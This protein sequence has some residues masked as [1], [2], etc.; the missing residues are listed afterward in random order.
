MKEILVKGAEPISGFFEPGGSKNAALPII[1]AAVAMRGVSVISR[2]PDILDVRVAIEII[3]RFGAYAEMQNGVLK[4]DATDLHYEKIPRE[5]TCKIRASSYLIGACLA[6]F[7]RFHLDDFGGCNFCNRPIDMHLQAAAVLGAEITDNFIYAEKLT[8]RI[9]AFEKPSVGATINALIMASCAKGDTLISG[10]AREPHVKNLIRF[11]CSA[12]ADIEDN[13]EALL[14]RGRPLFGGFVSVIP[15]MIEA[16]TFLLM[17]P[18]TGGKITVGEAEELE[19]ESFLSVLSDADIYVSKNGDKVTVCGEP[20]RAITLKTG[21]HPGFP[22][23]LQPQMA[24]LMAKYFGG[25][26]YEYVW[27]NRFSYLKA[28]DAFGVRSESCGSCAYIYPSM[29]KRG[30]AVCPDLRGGAAA[31]LCALSAEGKSKIKDADIIF[32]GYSELIPKLKK[33]GANVNISDSRIE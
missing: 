14:V 11:L 4:I 24:P 7:G 32:R 3:R 27:Q 22:T 33:L 12:G 1:F 23:D 6:R 15:D 19:L 10:A 29:I 13:G 9:I 2:V 16:G 8:G 5:L 30:V 20:K 26:I 28:L 18:M 25:N 21:P 31:L 17:A